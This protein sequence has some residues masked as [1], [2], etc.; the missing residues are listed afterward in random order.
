MVGLEVGVVAWT[1]ATLLM[2]ESSMPVST[3][4]GLRN[5][6]TNLEGVSMEGALEIRWEAQG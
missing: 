4:G 1:M 3:R 5:L 6:R 2:S